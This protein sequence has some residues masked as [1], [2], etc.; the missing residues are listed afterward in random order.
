MVYLKIIRI[1]A[2]KCGD[3]FMKRIL[4]YSLFIVPLMLLMAFVG[5]HTH[6]ETTAVRSGQTSHFNN[7]NPDSLPADSC[8]VVAEGTFSRLLSRNLSARSFIAVVKTA[9]FHSYHKS[10]LI[11]TRLTHQRLYS[12]NFLFITHYSR[13]A[14]DGYYIYVLRKLL[15]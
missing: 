5:I 4:P 13:K 6:E 8:F 2:R 15:I 3:N 14:K 1:F 9:N 11:F 10:N 12:V 7:S